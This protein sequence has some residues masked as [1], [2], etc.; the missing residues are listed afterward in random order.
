MVFVS[1][2]FEDNGNLKVPDIIFEDNEASIFLVKNQQVA[3]CTKHIITCHH[4]MQDAWEF[5]KLHVKYIS[6]KSNEAD[7]CT[8]N[9][10]LAL[11][12]KH[13]ERL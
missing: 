1:N 9:L 6:F 5:N 13:H 12:K 4:F 8:K 7:I 10:P 2:L 11:H 3:I